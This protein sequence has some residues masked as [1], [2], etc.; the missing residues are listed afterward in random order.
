MINSCD[1]LFPNGRSVI[2]FPA[3]GC[4]VYAPFPPSA[5]FLANSLNLLGISSAD[6]NLHLLLSEGMSPARPNRNPQLQL[7][8]G[9]TFSGRRRRRLSGY[10]GEITPSTA[11]RGTSMRFRICENVFPHAISFFH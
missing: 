9:D 6:H 5:L 4:E 11:G 2:G 10:V 1:A 7:S 3:A 8:I